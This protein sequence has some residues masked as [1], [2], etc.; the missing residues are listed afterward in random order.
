MDGSRSV[1]SLADLV[2]EE[3]QGSDLGRKRI[4][5]VVA[6]DSSDWRS[7]VAVLLEVEDEVEVVA[8]VENGQEA[9]EAVT[10]LHP[11]LVI[12]DLRIGSLD[13]LTT[14][15]LMHHQFPLL[16]IIL[17]ADRDW[18]RLRAT[19]HASGAKYFVQKDKFREQL[20]PVLGQIKN[21]RAAD[22]VRTDT[23]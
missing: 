14:A 18:P 20:L 2:S 1:E 21:F 19:C 4:R 8:H 10:V 7:I 6:D 12:I 23:K 9:I 5:A 11:E 3:R 16:E 13:A 15:S 22:V 17:M